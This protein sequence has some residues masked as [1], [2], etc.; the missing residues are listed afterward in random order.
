MRQKTIILFIVISLFSGGL[1]FD[2][3]IFAKSIDKKKTQVKTI[4]TREKTVFHY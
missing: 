2:P 3:G 1:I 4:K